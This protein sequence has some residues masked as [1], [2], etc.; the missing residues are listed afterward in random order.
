MKRN[1]TTSGAKGH[2]LAVGV[3]TTLPRD[4]RQPELLPAR[5]KKV[6]SW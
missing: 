3:E 6:I 1:K 2:Y 5:G 4:S